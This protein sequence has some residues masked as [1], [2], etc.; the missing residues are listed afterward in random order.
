MK[1]PW[2]IRDLVDFDYFLYRDEE[3]D[4]EELRQRDR[5]FYTGLEDLPDERSTLFH[6]WVRFRGE[7]EDA[8]PGEA[9]AECFSI[10]KIAFPLA[11]CLSGA[12]VAIGLL[13]YR[14]TVAVN[15]SSYV[16]VLV[17]LQLLLL[18][19]LLATL[20]YRRRT[21]G[22]GIPT[23]YPLLS[24]A[25]FRGSARIWRG[26]LRK[27]GGSQAGKLQSGLGELRLKNALYGR[28]IYQQVFQLAQ[29][30]GVLFNLGAL[31]M[32]LLRVTTGDLAFGWQSTVFSP[33]TV[34]RIGRSLALPWRWHWGE[35]VGYPS[36]EQVA[37]SKM[38][39]KEGMQ[40]LATSDLRSWLLFLCLCLAV[41]GFLPRLALWIY[42]ACRQARSLRCLSFTH[43]AGERLY[44]RMTTPMLESAGTSPGGDPHTFP[45]PD[46]T[47]APHPSTPGT[48]GNSTLLLVPEE[49]ADELEAD[50]LVRMVEQRIGRSVSRTCWYRPGKQGLENLDIE[51]HETVT[52]Y[53]EAWQP[54]IRETLTFIKQLRQHL[55]PETALVIL[56][57]GRA[58]PGE[59]FAPVKDI[60][61]STW[62]QVTRQLADPYL[63][64]AEAV[65]P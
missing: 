48:P 23:A 39:L 36:L 45:P 25:V 49:L 53:Q 57:N 13:H 31:G 10:L 18:L 8:T 55:A 16:G 51:P 64:I 7:A 4:G 61:R 20:L 1:A 47:P 26:S 59:S 5:A 14:G 21:L 22:S 44:R 11:G 24:R 27:G 32:T 15:V 29:A 17:V 41:Y 60:D 30:F 52:L 54:P 56:L 34:H 58:R 35:G 33:E 2:T 12:A 3:A 37:G 63:D 62:T 46:A 40:D 65:T 50:P 42:A 9:F 38:I 6:R 28:V 43:A 19:A